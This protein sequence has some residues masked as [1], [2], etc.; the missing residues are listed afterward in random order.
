MFRRENTR[1]FQKDARRQPLA[2]Q[3]HRLEHNRFLFF[4]PPGVWYLVIV[5]QESNTYSLDQSDL[6]FACSSQG[7]KEQICGGVE[8]RNR[9]E[10]GV[11]VS[12]QPQNSR[13]L[14]LLGPE[15]RAEEEFPEVKKGVELPRRSALEPNPPSAQAGSDFPGVQGLS[16]LCSPCFS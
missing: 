16:L 3:A 8:R 15:P 13:P 6:V 5:A 9:R 12:Q 10:A 2:L 1:G 7:Q 11:G 14:T 4:Q